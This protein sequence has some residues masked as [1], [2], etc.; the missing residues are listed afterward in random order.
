MR[1]NGLRIARE[2][3]VQERDVDH[4]GSLEVG[5]DRDDIEGAGWRS[6]CASG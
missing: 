1:S 6:G 5:D 4:E 3:G 2:R